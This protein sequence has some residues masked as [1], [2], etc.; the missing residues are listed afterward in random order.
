MLDKDIQDI[1]L[2]IEELAIQLTDMLNAA[3]FF[4][5]VKKENLKKAVDAY[6]DAIDEVFDEDDDSEMGLDEII[7]VINHIKRR[8]PKLFNS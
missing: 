7:T 1:E 5:G 8:E 6:L 3:L 4:A 2:E